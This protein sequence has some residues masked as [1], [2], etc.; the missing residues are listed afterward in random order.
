MLI[1]NSA[2]TVLTSSQKVTIN[3]DRAI[4]TDR[5]LGTTTPLSW[6][7][8]AARLD[9]LTGGELFLSP[10]AFLPLTATAVFPGEQFLLLPSEEEIIVRAPQSSHPLPDLT[11]APTLVNGKYTFSCYEEPAVMT[12]TYDSG[13]TEGVMTFAYEETGFDIIGTMT[14]RNHSL[15]TMTVTGTNRLTGQALPALQIAE[16]TLT[17]GSHTL[18]VDI[19]AFDYHGWWMNFFEF[20]NHSYRELF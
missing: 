3:R 5:S 11:A 17:R 10:G 6:D 18:I 15:A 1:T 19:R 2:V 7:D 13:T 12:F 16:S 4:A 20:V 14:Y 9:S 8:L